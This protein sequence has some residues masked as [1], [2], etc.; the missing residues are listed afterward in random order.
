MKKRVPSEFKFLAFILAALLFL[1]LP[2]LFAF[3]G[4]DELPRTARSD[5]AYARNAPL[6]ERDMA[7]DGLSFEQPLYL[8]LTKQPAELTAFVAS[9]NGQFQAFRTWP[10]CSVSGGLGPKLREGDEQAPEGFYSVKPE[11]MNPAST[12]HLSFNL[13]FPNAY[14]RAQGRTGSF[15]MVHGSCVSIGCFAMTDAGMEEIWTLM[16]AAFAGG[17]TAIPVH[18][19]PFPMTPD[20]LER[21]ANNANAEFWQALTPAWNAFE[22]NGLVPDV[23]VRRGDYVVRAAQ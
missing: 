19:F 11:A 6:L 4:A 16:Q 10:V 1:C 2:A 3:A 14:D 21:H 5:A 12:Y 13:G 8:R 18:I 9:Q 17:Q 20:N 22:T 15:L 7:A 23:A